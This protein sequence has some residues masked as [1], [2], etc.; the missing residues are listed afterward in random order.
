MEVSRWATGV[1]HSSVLEAMILIAKHGC[2]D[3][4]G[5][6]AEQV[7]Q[8]LLVADSSYR[9]TL[10]HT[11]E[12]DRSAPDCASPDCAKSIPSTQA[13]PGQEGRRAD[14]P[15]LEGL[16]MEHGSGSWRLEP[17]ASNA[18]DS[19]MKDGPSCTDDRHHGQTLG[20][21]NLGQLDSLEQNTGQSDAR[22]EA[23]TAE[24]PVRSSQQANTRQD[25]EGIS[26]AETGQSMICNLDPSYKASLQGTPHAELST[27]VGH[28]DEQIARF[29]RACSLA[30]ERSSPA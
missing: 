28:V 9:D 12:P 30:N 10:K 14:H 11:S 20:R 16:D 3:H 2:A 8:T 1:H 29:F 18:E 7:P 21:S 19:A 4:G 5:D 22:K 26:E 15:Q 25:C 6:R 17:K 24:L 23:G 13:E 27:G